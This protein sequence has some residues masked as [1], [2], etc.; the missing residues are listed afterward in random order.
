MLCLLIELNAKADKAALE[1]VFSMFGR[2]LL[3]QL[4]KKVVSMDKTEYVLTSL[5]KTRNKKWELYVVS[6]IYHLLDD[7]DIE[8]V[9][10]QLIR[11]ENSWYLVDLFF[12]QLGIF[13]E[14]DE[15]HHLSHQEADALRSKE[16]FYGTGLSEKRIDVCDNARHD[17]HINEVDKQVDSFVDVI[18]REKVKKMESGKFKAWDYESRF[19]PDPHIKRGQICLGN[20]AVFRTHKD[21]LRC[22]GFSGSDHRKAV[23]GVGGSKEERA[24]TCV[25]FPKLYRND[26]WDNS[27]DET[28]TNIYEKRIEDPKGYIRDNP[29]KWKRRIV[30]AHERDSFGKTL[31]KFK[32]VFERDDDS[33]SDDRV[34][35]Q[36]VGECVHLPTAG[37]REIGATEQNPQDESDRLDD[38]LSGV[39][40]TPQAEKAIK[41]GH[42]DF[43]GSGVFNDWNT[44][45]FGQPCG[46]KEKLL[47]CITDVKSSADVIAK[48]L[49][50]VGSSCREITTL[51]VFAV[52]INRDTWNGIWRLFYPSFQELENSISIEIEIV[53][54][55][56]VSTQICTICGVRPVSTHREWTDTWSMKTIRE[57]ACRKCASTPRNIMT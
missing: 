14:I 5:A 35:Y 33:N 6:R 45:P 16:I 9:C 19:S 22:F 26:G 55:Q 7:P 11:T 50:H 1:Y 38:G 52:Y 15:R 21:A 41:E 12:P 17:R 36:R 56:E 4:I 23:W 40:Q 53:F 32:G 2:V 43:P 46:C 47:A 27:I 30:F 49:L 28:Q 13:L 57:P 51:L 44:L 37:V 31:Y 34:V 48:A 3:C 25:W 39:L 29:R 20:G 8:F 18:R 24:S 54:G 10:Q 42:I